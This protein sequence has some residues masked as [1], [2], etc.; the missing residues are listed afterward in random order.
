MTTNEILSMDINAFLKLSYDDLKQLTQT[1]SSTANKRIKRIVN[2]EM[3]SP[4]VAKV[5]THGGLFSTKGKNLNQLRQEFTRAKNFLQS[6]TS[7]ISGYKTWKRKTISR[8]KD[9]NISISEQEFFDFWN[10]YNQ[11]EE[12]HPDIQEKS[13]KYKVMTAISRMMQDKRRTV[14]SIVRKMEEELDDIETGE[15]EWI[16]DYDPRKNTGFSQYFKHNTKK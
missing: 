13:F 15:S 14:K 8:M 16:K 11:L 3:S 2:K 7:T 5:I 6:Q 4:A 1:L 10:I 12:R 9:R